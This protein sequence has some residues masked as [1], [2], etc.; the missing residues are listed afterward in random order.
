MGIYES[1]DDEIAKLDGYGYKVIDRLD[2]G[3][4]IML[5]LYDDMYNIYEISLTTGDE[6]FTTFDSQIKR[7]TTQTKGFWAFKILMPKVWEWVDKYGKLM[8]GSMNRSRTFVYARL[9]KNAGFDISDVMVNEP[10]GYFP[11][12]YNFVVYP[13]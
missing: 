1:I 3:P 7:P 11:E 9:F 8:V 2:A 5:L 6:E 4:Y 10:D 13:N 12:S